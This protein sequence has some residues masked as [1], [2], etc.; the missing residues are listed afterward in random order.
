MDK[1]VVAIK[2]IYTKYNTN[3]LVL[4]ELNKIVNQIPQNL[5]D[6][7]ER[8][9]QQTKITEGT[10]C[11]VSF[12]NNPEHCY[13]Y[14]KESE[15]F[16]KY[17]GEHYAIINEDDI[18]Q[19]IYTNLKG[20]DTKEKHIIKN[21]IIECIHEKSILNSIPE[22][23]TIQNIINFLYP[24]LLNS[25]EESKY[26][27]SILGD[28]ILKKNRDIIH[29]FSLNSK[30]FINSLN[31][32]SFDYIEKSCN[33]SVKWRYYKH[34][35]SKCRILNFNNAI[36]SERYWSDFLKNNILDLI[37]VACHYSE[38]YNCSEEYLMKHIFNNSVKSH[39]LYLQNKNEDDVVSD[40]INFIDL[41][42]D[43]TQINQISWDIIYFVWKQYLHEKN[44]P[45][46]VFIEPLK[47][48]I[49]KKIYN[50]EEVEI[51]DKL[52]CK[53]FDKI[54]S[55]QKFWQ[56]TISDNDKEYCNYEIG[57]ICNMYREWINVDSEVSYIN[58]ENM[59]TMIKFFY[60]KLNII[61]NK[62]IKNISCSFWLKWEDI[63]K[64]YD[65]YKNESHESYTNVSKLYEDYCKYNKNCLKNN[66]VAKDYFTKYLVNEISKR[67]SEF[68]I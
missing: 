60:P 26:F 49:C 11:V 13:Y 2:K 12:L 44:Y 29:Y 64:W 27:L 48:H 54:L 52:S 53:K 35:F 7:I 36:M 30:Q 39:I 63:D 23:K 55:L 38:R 3:P 41:K 1:L 33:I 34:L 32:S 14:I 42:Y 68:S 67:D 16:V 61:K 62:Y 66:P 47:R 15:S 17:D 46:V 4:E 22:S 20:F 10:K 58:H 19:T 43:S 51:F 37:A 50:K 8:N 31:C 59:L 6:F 28:N 25:K 5:N 45:N 24:T 56:T 65:D 40:F 18:W 9:K 21:T 57:E